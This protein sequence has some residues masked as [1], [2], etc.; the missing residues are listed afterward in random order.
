[1]TDKLAIDGGK[2]VRDTFLA[3]GIPCLGEEES[4]EMLNTLQSG[5]IGTG[6]KTKRFEEMLAAYVG[7]PL[8]VT[9][10][11]CTAGLFLSL[12][13]S[14]IG[15][16]DE[17]ITTSMTFGATANAIIH[18]GARPVFADI[19]PVTL[20]IDP[21]NIERVI[22]SRTRAILPVHF[23]GLAC[24]MDA[25][26]GIANAHKLAVI[27][28]AAHAIGTR[29]RGRMIGGMGNLTSFSFY[30]NKNMT[31]GEGGAII[32]DDPA[33]AEQLQAYR[34]HGLNKHA[35]Q[36]Y[37]SHR[38]MLSDV[39]VPGYKFNMTDM[40]A[41]L[42]IHQLNKLESFLEIR[43]KYARLYDEVFANWDGI[44]LQL[45]PENAEDRHALH[46]Y[47]LIIS[48]ERFKVS[49]NQ[50]IDAILAENIGAALHYRA[51]H[52]H[53]YYV[54]TFGYKPEDYPHALT[55][56]ESIFSLPL[57]PKMTDKDVEDVIT[58]VSRVLKAFQR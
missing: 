16:G 53:P 3:F 20:N 4:N 15:P 14:G 32:V 39:V 50:I 44:R 41:S 21:A 33:L 42:G 43:T 40:Q 25:I 9:V 7:A 58:A 17:V 48:P 36:R 57:S 46:L 47:T 51:L 30:P 22:T 8:A 37:T 6:P 5:W 56:G 11:S 49:R 24:D 28:D 55:V 18:C 38:L 19:D 27:E 23:G 29:Y 12:L 52:T 35:W 31:T 1:M 10:N 13:V 26:H 34:L 45:R 2:P 54:R